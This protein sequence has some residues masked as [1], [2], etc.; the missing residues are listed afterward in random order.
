MA[1]YLAYSGMQDMFL[2]ENPDFTH[3]K[4]LF[5][6]EIPYSTKVIE[7]TFD[8][9]VYRPGDT[10]ISTIRQ[11]GDY[12]TN[13]TLKIILP[14]ITPDNQYFVYPDYS[15]FY[16]KTMRVFDPSGTEIYN[17]VLN[18]LVPTTQNENWFIVNT[19]IVS[20]SFVT[21]E[22]G[23][24]KFEVTSPSCYAIFDDIETANFW[25]F[26]Y[27]PI[28]LF[29]G[30]IRFNSV[31][32]SQ[33]TFQESGWLEGNEIY[34]NTYSY[35][36]DT[37]YKLI[38]SIGL[39]IGKQLIQEFDSTYIKFYNDTNNSYKNR[40]VLKLLEGND[41]IVDFNRV[42][43]FNLPFINVP[44]YA[45]PRQDIQIRFKTNPFNYVNFY[46]SI[47]L[48]FSLFGDAKLTKNYFIQVP[49]VSYFTENDLNIQGP[50]KKL[51]TTGPEDY[52]F[53]MNG[54]FLFDPEIVKT[55]AFEN[56]K[57]LPTESNVY[58]F[59][60]MINMSRIRDQN[61]NSSNTNVYAETLNILK[62]SD[63]ISGL[64]FKNTETGGYP[65]LDGNLTNPLETPPQTY[66]YNEISLSVPNIQTIYS[67]RVVNPSYTGPV[68]RVRDGDTDV[69]YDLYTD[70]TQS[71]LK[72]S[73]GVSVT[74]LNVSN[75]KVS[76]WYDQSYY[77]NNA[78]QV[79]KTYQPDLVLKDGKYVI[80]IFNS[81]LGGGFPPEKF[82]DISNNIHPQQFLM[83]INMNRLGNFTEPVTIFGTTGEFLLRTIGNS[84]NASGAGD[85]VNWYSN[86]QRANMYINGVSSYIMPQQQWTTIS[87]YLPGVYSGPD[88]AIIGTS[89]PGFYNTPLR[90]FDGYMFEMGWL[91]NTSMQYD[92][93]DYNANR[94]PV[95]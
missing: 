7:Q 47:V 31:S 92:Y 24:F 78:L 32:S 23:K 91:K 11:N 45:I 69:E 46:A 19:N 61:F 63:D 10:L 84:F 28:K 70:S 66:L 48:K 14:K 42:Y 15:K 43:Y 33:L 18:G 40:P 27:N 71:Y 74:N 73:N 29:S 85:W 77:Q 55:S 68:V 30:F 25:G 72:T 76:V 21:I 65:I 94:P 12:I 82:L 56:F 52:T 44:M 5:S 90:S 37:V 22:N 88:V 83:T 36:D 53:S 35:L 51:I 9:T 87:S 67:M 62:V 26:T 2:T 38:N 95:F 59:N 75:L 57:N 54:E 64:L 58:V 8:Q 49:Q 41:N 6:R 17:L 16:G 50:I 34:N 79:A 1:V 3:F 89:A 20:E 13:M 93:V 60:N 39:Y 4:T 80:G 81:T 86:V